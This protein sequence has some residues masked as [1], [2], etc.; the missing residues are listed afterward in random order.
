MVSSL[1]GASFRSVDG[2]RTRRSPG[3]STSRSSISRNP[4]GG[5]ASCKGFAVG[6]ARRAADGVCAGRPA[7]RLSVAAE[8]VRQM[9]LSW[10]YADEQPERREWV[11]SEAAG[12][13][14]GRVAV[15]EDH[16]LHCESLH[17]A[18]SV[19]PRAPRYA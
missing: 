6:A 3:A 1:G 10:S 13:A 7:A 9:A 17:K 5:G 2:D 18:I 16:L 11:D 8:G 12:A 14:E 19:V 15:V 4:G